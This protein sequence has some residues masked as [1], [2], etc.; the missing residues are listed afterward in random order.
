ME[1]KMTGN[2]AEKPEEKLTVERIL[3][4]IRLSFPYEWEFICS[5]LSKEETERIAENF[6][7]IDNNFRGP[8][9]EFFPEEIHHRTDT[10]RCMRCYTR[11]LGETRGKMWEEYTF[12]YVHNLL[13]CMREMEIQTVR[14]GYADYTAQD[15]ISVWNGNHPDEKIEEWRYIKDGGWI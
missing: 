3:T 1:E 11:L 2:M 10:E 4:K 13:L 5:K 12:K 14:I 8:F 15:I 9:E 7:P 6:I